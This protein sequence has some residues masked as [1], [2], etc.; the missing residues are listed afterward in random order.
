M[1][2][3]D[4]RRF[5]EIGVVCINGEPVPRELWPYVRPKSRSDVIVTLHTPL[6]RGRETS[7]KDTV[8]LVAAIA[9]I[10]I[11]T[12]VTA[13]AAA[14]LAE[15]LFTGAGATFAAGTFGA[16]VLA[17]SITIV[18]ALALGAFVKPPAAKV[19]D[20]PPSDEGGIP[21]ALQGNQLKRGGAIPR[22][23]G[24]HR[25]F[26]PFLSQPLIDI[27]GYDEV[28]EAVYGFAGP[29]RMRDFKFGDTFVD[30]IDPEQLNYEFFQLNEEDV[31]GIDSHVQLYAKLNGAQDAVVFNDSSEHERAIAVS[32]TGVFTDRRAGYIATAAA[33]FGAAGHLSLASSPDFALGSNP[34][35]IDFFVEWDGAAATAANILGHTATDLA[36]TDSSFYFAKTSADKLQF[37]IFDGSTTTTLLSTVT[38]NSGIHHIAVARIANTLYL[39]VDGFLQTST[40]FTGSVPTCLSTFNIGSRG[41][42]VTTTRWDG[43]ISNFRFSVAKT[44]YTSSANFTPPTIWYKGAT[45]SLI[46]RYG[47]TQTPNIVLSDHRIE[48]DQ[49]TQAS[50]DLVSNQTAPGR[51]NPQAQSVVGRGSGFDEVWVTLTLQSGLF[52]SDTG[53]SADWFYA[54]PFRIRIRE[55][56]TDTWFNLPEVHVHDRRQAPFSRLLVF[57][58]DSSILNS[59][60]TPTPP[61][62]RKGWRAAFYTVPAQDQAPVGIGGWQADSHF[63]DGSGDKYLDGGANN[64]STSGLKNIRLGTESA[65]FFLDG[66][67]TKGPIEVEVRKGQMYTAD[68]FTYTLSYRL[69]TDPPTDDLGN[70][71]FDFFGYA[72]MDGNQVI[73]LKQSSGAQRCVITRVSTVWNALPVARGGVFS[74]IY[75]KASNRSLDALSVLASGLVPDWDGAAWSGLHATSNPAPHYRDVLIGSLNDN[76]IDPSMVNDTTLLEWRQRCADLSFSCNAVFNGE[77][78]DRVL[79]V[80]A[81]CGYARP[82]QAELWDV[83][84]DRDFTN[85]APVQMF[86]PRNMA[87]FR[88]EKAFVRHRPDGLRVRYN[89]ETDSYIEHTIVVPRAGYGSASGGRLEEIRYDGPTTELD[90]VLRALYDQQQVI[91]RFT[92]YHGTV[93]AEMLVC[94]RGDLVLVQHDTLDQFAGFSRILSLDSTDD[95]VSAIRLDGTVSPIDKFFEEPGDFFT[96]PTD[97]FTDDAGV[98]IRRKD[99]TTVSFQAQVAGD[100]FILIPNT[101]VSAESLERE[102]LVQTGRLLSANRR[103]LVY[104][105]KPKADLTADITFV[106]EAPQ[107]WQFPEPLDVGE[108]FMR[109]RVVNGDMSLF[110]RQFHTRSLAVAANSLVY[111]LDRWWARLTNNGGALTI[112]QE[113][114]ST[115]PGFDQFLRATVTTP[116]SPIAGNHQI[117]QVLSRTDLRG[118]DWGKTASARMAAL[119]FNVR[120]SL[121]GTYYGSLFYE[122]GGYNYSYVFAYTIPVANEWFRKIVTITAPTGVGVDPTDENATLQ[123]EWSLGGSTLETT[124]LEQWV[125]GNVRRGTFDNGFMTTMGATFDLTGVQFEPTPATVFEWLPDQ[126]AFERA[127]RFYQNVLVE[128]DTLVIGSGVAISS[129]QAK[130]VIPRAIP[131]RAPPVVGVTAAA[132]LQLRAASGAIVATAIS[133]ESPVSSGAH[134]VEVLITV[135]AGLTA[136]Q[137]VNLELAANHIEFDSEITPV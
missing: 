88:W 37:N 130:I 106:D 31:A 108:E 60:K 118:F 82:R 125:E 65:E 51:S 36:V 116:V 121:A 126:L 97:F 43:W 11:A 131:L 59:G 6:H 135:A 112:T 124:S 137:A 68:K 81:G 120:S 57:R 8:R 28:I 29:H 48:N 21:A 80:I 107:L 84:Q 101:P 61:A 40:A 3:L 96:T 23:I 87:G 77:H 92:F 17:G 133:L 10:A 44:W 99:G 94:R 111:S 71:I 93:D 73:I 136:G 4:T 25:A 105:I 20:K 1:P 22:V 127:F 32:G 24:T 5:L 13:G 79:E 16:Q 30:D 39:W 12:A 38:I 64:L 34:F 134:A 49:P 63:Y 62:A 74:T 103:M 129:T 114:S 117:G 46:T 104:D 41:D 85:I 67:V 122:V 18:G 15:T 115:A 78:V 55:L 113:T 35:S 27:N 91:D 56:G 98:C 75:V 119:S 123:I 50:R 53:F 42:D 109:N 90:A 132:N 47:K 2:D 66:L 76:R 83:A 7:G 9:L 52:Y 100:G 19:D 72:T 110:S 102:C 89:E 54:I 95:V 26:P 58:W 70:G 14:P 45:P 128:S 33:F 69:D 86:T